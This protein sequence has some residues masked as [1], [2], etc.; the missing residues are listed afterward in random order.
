M[1]TRAWLYRLGLDGKAAQYIRLVEDTHRLPDK[2]IS[3]PKKPQAPDLLENFRDEPQ[4]LDDINISGRDLIQQIND[5]FDDLQLVPFYFSKIAKKVG[6]G[7]SVGDYVCVPGLDRPF[8]VLRIWIRYGSV[9]VRDLTE[10]DDIQYLFPWDMIRP[11][12][13]D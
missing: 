1:G 8:Q 9:R 4:D 11:W 6:K 2:E 5:D 3:E 12:E 10:D 13:E 7:I